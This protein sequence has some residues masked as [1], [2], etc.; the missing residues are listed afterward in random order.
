M[1]VEDLLHLPAL[2]SAKLIAGSNG[3][4]RN[5]EWFHIIDIPQILPWINEGDILFSS[6]YAFQSNHEIMDGLIESLNEKGV[7]ALFIAEEIY[8]KV[9]PSQMLAVAEQLDFPLFVFPADTKLRD[10]TRQ[11][12]E[13]LLGNADAFFQEYDAFQQKT[14]EIVLND[15]MPLQNLVKFLK[16]KI[17]VDVLLLDA[18]GRLLVSGC[19]RG[20]YDS[21]LKNFRQKNIINSIENIG[22]PITGHHKKSYFYYS[23]LY[24]KQIIYLVILKNIEDSSI[25]ELILIKNIIGL[26]SGLISTAEVLNNSKLNAQIPLLE[27][28]L[29]GQYAS[30]S[31]VYSKA[32]ELG[33]N[34]DTSHIAVVFDTNNYNKH[35]VRNEMNEKQIKEFRNELISELIDMIKRIQG[36]YPVIRQELVFTS[37]FKLTSSSS[38]NRIIQSCHEIIY[39]IQKKYGIDLLVGVSTVC[40][41]LTGLSARLMEA[42][43]VIEIIKDM[44]STSLATYDQ[45]GLE[46]I[47]NRIIMDTNLKQT[48]IKRMLDLADYDIQYS[49]DLIQTLRVLVNNQGNVAQTARNLNVHRNTIKYRIQK[50]EEIIGI[51]LSSA[52]VFLNISILLKIYD[53]REKDSKNVLCKN[54]ASL[55]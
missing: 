3:L 16:G 29:N 18:F 31:V 30:E 15:R 26:I 48:F 43:D 21:F 14:I 23:L 44:K 11:L 33:W 46:I 6:G 39:Y 47:V 53:I 37:I 52:N 28:I 32:A 54:I 49:S 24:N 42:K 20:E 27:S 22:I 35:I 1:T 19:I 9:V 38:E 34:M 50:I 10:V 51:S 55:D 8:L 12:S 5:V 40:K 25:T 17:G 7:S 45:V 41:E 36:I 2:S 13:Y 4:N